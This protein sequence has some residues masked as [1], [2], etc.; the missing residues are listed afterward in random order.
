MRILIL[1]NLTLPINY[2]F[3]IPY[4]PSSPM[5]KIK[6]TFL[7]TGDAI[8]TKKR[9]HS[10]I[11][12]SYR[13]ENILVDCG[14]GTQRQFRIANISPT[15]ITK[16]L[17]THWH[18]DHILGLPGLLQTLAASNYPRTLEIYGPKGTEYYYSLLNKIF[19][20]NLKVL[21]KEVS[22]IFFQTSDFQLEAKPMDHQT[23]TNAYSFTIKDKTRL[24]R[25]KIKALKLPNSPLLGQ[26]QKGKSI[27]W[28]G[29][30][31][32][33]KQVS[34]SEKGKKVTFILDTAENKN[35][36][37]LAKLSDLLIIEST[38]SA[39]EKQKAEDYKHLTSSQA[40]QTAKKAKVKSLILTHL[41]QRYDN[42]QHQILSEARKTFKNT[43]IVKD[44]DSL[45]I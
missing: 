22:G 23:P 39:E 28:K 37:E 16:I 19:N 33:P 27:S 7:G 40:A 42:K 34:Y 43:K 25:K 35:A 38:F 14:E 29:K 30:T 9:S 15:K 12:L 41:S 18:G 8:P 17:I 26:L 5:D 44:F 21:I 3:Y 1:I 6:I 13:N 20:L 45:E 36:L 32:S 4:L 11:L 10:A 2:K 24:D 31:I